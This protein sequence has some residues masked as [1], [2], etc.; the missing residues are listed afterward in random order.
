MFLRYIE[1]VLEKTALLPGMACVNSTR[2]TSISF[3]V[4][5]F[6]LLVITVYFKNL[7]MYAKSQKNNSL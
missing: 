6:L 1:V 2:I 4:R 5:L 3:A 7:S